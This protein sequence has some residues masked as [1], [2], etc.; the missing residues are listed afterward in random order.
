MALSAMY[1]FA[2]LTA[3]LGLAGAPIYD[4]IA[5]FALLAVVFQG[6]VPSR[7][8]SWNSAIRPNADLG[9]G[10]CDQDHDSVHQGGLPVFSP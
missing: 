3:T 10:H 5:L 1:V 9:P 6:I 4:V 7:T 2:V 8:P